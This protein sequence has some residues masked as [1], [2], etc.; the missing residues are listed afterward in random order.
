MSL[1]GLIVVL[2]LVGVALYLIPM[3]EKIKRTVVVIVILLAV[4]W[5]LQAFG[6]FHSF[7]NIHV[8]A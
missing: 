3:E 7:P 1:V 5:L 6:V 8:G 4:L 2:I